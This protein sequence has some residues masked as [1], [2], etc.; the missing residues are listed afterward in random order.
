M[1]IKNI[2]TKKTFDALIV[3]F[4]SI[5]STPWKTPANAKLFAANENLIAAGSLLN[6]SLHVLAAQFVNKGVTRNI[7]KFSLK[8]VGNYKKN[9]TRG[10]C[11]I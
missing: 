1:Y 3:F 4:G 5:P 6:L 8:I 2:S 10:I 9:Q 11:I 7:K